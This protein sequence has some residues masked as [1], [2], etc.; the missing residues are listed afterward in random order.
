MCRFP[1][2]YDR[3][4]NERITHH[5]VGSTGVSRD[6][7]CTR[8]DDV[9]GG[10]GK[11]HREMITLKITPDSRLDNKNVDELAKALY[12]YKSPLERMHKGKLLPPNFLSFE[13]V[14]EK[15]NT[16]FYLTIP[17]ENESI[18]KKT[19]TTI[20]PKSA[21]RIDS[22]IKLDAIPLVFPLP[23]PP[24]TILGRQRIS[25]LFVGK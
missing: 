5:Q 22:T 13:T 4:Q 25:W 23:I 18:A 17:S 10:S 6:A 3:K 16:S 1:S 12:Q 7:V 24:I 11:V 15:E 2:Y 9:V 19:L 14:L 21:L 8:I 20:F